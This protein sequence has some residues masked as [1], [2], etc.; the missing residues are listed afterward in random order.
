[1]MSFLLRLHHNLERPEV[2][3]P[4]LIALLAAP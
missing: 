3:E 4:A 2:V 1:V